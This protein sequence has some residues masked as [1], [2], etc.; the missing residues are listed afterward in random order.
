M[1]T[2]LAVLL[3]HR[4]R[5]H[6]GSVK[7]ELTSL[8]SAA[9]ALPIKGVSKMAALDFLARFLERKLAVLSLRPPKLL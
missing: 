5:P 4:E 6:P 3:K 1:K 2:V 7:S 8:P 9:T